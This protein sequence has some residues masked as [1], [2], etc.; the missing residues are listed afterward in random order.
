MPWNPFT[1][2][3]K[4]KISESN[5]KS[6][7][8]AAA[9]YNV[10]QKY[11]RNSQSKVA[12]ILKNPGTVQYT[13]QVAM[14]KQKLQAEYEKKFFKY[15]QFTEEVAK[16]LREFGP[17]QAVTSALTQVL[18]NLKEGIQKAESAPSGIQSGGGDVALI[19]PITVAKLLVAILGILISFVTFLVLSPL[20]LYTMMKPKNNASNSQ[21]LQQRSHNQQPRLQEPPLQQQRLQVENED[22]QQERRLQEGSQN[23]S[24]NEDP[25]VGGKKT[26]KNRK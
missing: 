7:A 19:I 12:N 13:N 10:R 26:R 16:P 23:Q 2:K 21:G 8:A 20:I 5:A 11:G 4:P 22:P 18:K 14:N 15:V 1:R 17:P 25:I 3:N 9:R 24:Q 6:M